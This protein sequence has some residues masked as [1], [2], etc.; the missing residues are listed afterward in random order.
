MED[1][2]VPDDF[3]RPPGKDPNEDIDIDVPQTKGVLSWE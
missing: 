3:Q 2:T 1:I